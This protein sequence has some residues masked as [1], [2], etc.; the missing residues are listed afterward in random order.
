MT[1]TKKIVG[2]LDG[3]PIVEGDMNEVGDNEY[4]LYRGQD[5]TLYKRNQQNRGINILDFP[6]TDCY[7]SLATGR[8]AGSATGPSHIDGSTYIGKRA[9]SMAEVPI[10]RLASYNNASFIFTENQIPDID[11]ATLG[12]NLKDV[13]IPPKNAPWLVALGAENVFQSV[14][15][16]DAGYNSGKVAFGVVPSQAIWEKSDVPNISWDYTLNCRATDG[17]VGL[18]YAV[19]P[20]VTPVVTVVS[21]IDAPVGVLLLEVYRGQFKNIKSVVFYD[22]EVYPNGFLNAL[23]EKIKETS[24]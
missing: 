7:V 21:D 13:A 8:N 20:R 16:V 23:E 14:L 12:R 18:L 9:P 15:S 6:E 2:K 4:Y 24:K 11:T 19:S 3:I 22:P 5:L 17:A 10:T 1:G